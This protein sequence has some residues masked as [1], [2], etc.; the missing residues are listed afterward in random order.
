MRFNALGRDVLAKIARRHLV[1][2]GRERLQEC[3]IDQVNLPEIRL[4][5]VGSHTRP[6]LHEG[7]SMDVTAY[8]D[9]CDQLDLT[10]LV[11]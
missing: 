2:G 7:S 1:P 6:V 3:G 9:S 8:T 11:L 4:R 5:G 10:D